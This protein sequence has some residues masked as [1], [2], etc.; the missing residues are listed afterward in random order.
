MPLG[1]SCRAPSGSKAR[2]RNTSHIWSQSQTGRDELKTRRSWTEQHNSAP[3]N[4][5]EDLK[6]IK[7]L[8]PHQEW[9]GGGSE[10]RLSY[11]STT[12]NLVEL[13]QTLV[14]KRNQ[15]TSCSNDGTVK[16]Q[17]CHLCSASKT[18]TPSKP[19]GFAEKRPAVFV[20]LCDGFVLGTNGVT[21]AAQ[22]QFLTLPNTPHPPPQNPDSHLDT[23]SEGFSSC[24]I[25]LTCHYVLSKKK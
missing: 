22:S 1:C 13:K 18:Q 11:L 5:P 25:N 19:Q 9:K 14:R 4:A 16:Q 24:F 8:K 20:Y 23:M 2:R 12:I 10:L 17:T 7:G 15:I 6:T 3:L 21:V